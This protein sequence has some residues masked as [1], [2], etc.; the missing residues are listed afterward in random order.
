MIVSLQ[1]SNTFSTLIL[2]FESSLNVPRHSAIRGTFEAITNELAKT[3]K[4]QL[5]EI[6]VLFQ[7]LLITCIYSEVC[8]TYTI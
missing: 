8:P 6:Q 1:C 5:K 2:G 7:L 3:I 4:I